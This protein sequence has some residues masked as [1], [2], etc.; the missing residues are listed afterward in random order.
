MKNMWNRVIVPWFTIICKQPFKNGSRTAAT[1]QYV[2][3]SIEYPCVSLSFPTFISNKFMNKIMKKHLSY[4]HF[5]ASY[6]IR[7]KSI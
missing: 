1:S 7:H 5:D 6:R 2:A 3:Y 4:V